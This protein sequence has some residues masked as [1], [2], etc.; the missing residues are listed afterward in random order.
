MFTKYC[1]HH[2]FIHNAQLTAIHNAQ[3][4]ILQAAISIDYV[5]IDALSI[6]NV[7]VVRLHTE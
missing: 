3:H 2:R 7:C 6:Q 1:I 4:A 5:L